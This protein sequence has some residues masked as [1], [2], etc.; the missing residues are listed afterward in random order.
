VLEGDVTIATTTDA[1]G[2]SELSEITGS[3]VIA[4]SFPGVLSLPNLQQVGGDVHLEGNAVAGAPESTWASITELRL[5]N[6]QSIGGE[7]FLYLTGALVETD[8]RSLETVGTRV[9]YMRNLALRRIGLD[10]ITT[11]PVDIQASPLAASCEIDAICARIGS[12]GCGSQYSDPDCTC[13]EHCG[14]LEP[15]CGG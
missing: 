3:L 7:L 10:S 6:L 15:S 14:R 2:A 12:M 13:I 5:P 8:F 1:E 9:Y 11:G 4:A